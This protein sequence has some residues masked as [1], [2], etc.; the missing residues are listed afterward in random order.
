MNNDLQYHNIKYRVDR[1]RGLSFGK[2]SLLM[3]D[4]NENLQSSSNDLGKDIRFLLSKK[5]LDFTP[6]IRELGGQLYYIKSGSTGH[7]FKSIFNEDEKDKEYAVKVVAYSRKDTYG[8]LFNSERPENVEILMLRLLSDFVKNKKTPH[9]VL[10]IITFNTDIN[11]FIDL[12]KKGLVTHRRYDT[13]V[14]KYNN[15]EFFD[16]VSILISEWAN[17]GDLMDYVRANYKKFTLK[18]WRTMFFQLLSVLAVIQYDYPS[19]RHNDLKANN[20]LI[21]KIHKS[22][23]VYRYDIRGDDCITTYVVPNIGFLIKIWDFDFACIPG[24]INNNKVDAEWTKTINVNPEQNRYYDVHYFFNTFTSKMFFPQFWEDERI[25]QKVKDFILRIIP[26]KY[27]EGE[28]VSKKGRILINDE[29]LTP[30]E[31]LRTDKFFKSFRQ[32]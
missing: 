4:N 2:T 12:P 17:G 25:P 6:V 8:D 10:P 27:R 29:Y 3:D 15:G 31:I 21:Q 1:I 22:K 13:F 23:K 19:F 32:N 7:T 28:N 5:Y 14:E 24:L 26:E 30:E 11:T 20:I 9:I 16:K 18:E